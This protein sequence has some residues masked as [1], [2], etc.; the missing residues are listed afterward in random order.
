MAELKTKPTGKSVD[1]YLNSIEDPVRQKDCRT[2]AGIME[3]LTGSPGRMWGDTI[4]GYGDYHYKYAS[5]REGDW[6]LAGFSSRKQSLTLYVMGYLE[7][8]QDHLDKLGKHKH[9]KGC[10][11]INKLEDVDMGVLKDLI[12]TSIERLKDQ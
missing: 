12:K 9:G 8:Y 1:D 3:D 5:G 10:L 6:F 2:I 7:F 4:V 11:Y